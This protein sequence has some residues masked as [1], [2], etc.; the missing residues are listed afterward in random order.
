MT[1]HVQRR[2]FVADVIFEAFPTIQNA[3]VHGEESGE[4]Q[5]KNHGQ[6]RE[7]GEYS[8]GGGI[9][10]CPAQGI[11]NPPHS[12]A[13]R[14]SVYRIRQ[15]PASS[16]LRRGFG[17]CTFEHFPGPEALAITCTHAVLGSALLECGTSTP[18]NRNSTCAVYQT[19]RR[20]R[21][22]SRMTFLSEVREAAEVESWVHRKF[23][24][25]D[26]P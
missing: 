6:C 19:H 16:D 13:E 25:R 10:K 18:R 12:T 2:L 4:Q 3:R 9:R 20:T 11:R 26:G 5:A 24:R 14:I 15:I 8:R 22:W 7:H 1:V 23:P 17:P 21:E